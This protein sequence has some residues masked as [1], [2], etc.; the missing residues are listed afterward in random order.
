MHKDNSRNKIEVYTPGV[1]PPCPGFLFT[2][3]GNHDSG[4]NLSNLDRELCTSGLRKIKFHTGI[5][6]MMAVYF[7]SGHPN[8]KGDPAR[9]GGHINLYERR[10]GSR[11]RRRE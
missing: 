8:V 6:G 9:N 11:S 5:R 7:Y 2:S 3:G 10:Y 1:E 4:G